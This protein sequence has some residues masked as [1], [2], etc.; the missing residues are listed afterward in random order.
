VANFIAL[1]PQHFITNGSKT[2]WKKRHRL[3]P[4]LSECYNA[5]QFCGEKCTSTS[6]YIPLFSIKLLSLLSSIAF[7][8]PKAL[9]PGCFRSNIMIGDILQ[10][11]QSIPIS[12]RP[13]R[14]RSFKAFGTRHQNRNRFRIQ[15]NSVGI[16]A[17]DAPRGLIRCG[18][19]TFTRHL[20][21]FI[22]QMDRCVFAC[23]WITYLY[24]LF[25]STRLRLKKASEQ[26]FDE[27]W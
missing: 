14:S 9:I 25:E 8:I 16:T 7:P 12:G 27:Y 15:V 1:H 13:D 26:G 3:F 2:S 17:G 23:A 10:D 4:F 18:N 5:S 21:Y 20:F 22:V 24:D 6:F 19:E 11:L